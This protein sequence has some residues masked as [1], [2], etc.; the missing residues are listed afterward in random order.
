MRLN[1]IDYAELPL[2]VMFTKGDIEAIHE[3]FKDHSDAIKNCKR[4]HAMEQIAV[5]FADINAKLEEV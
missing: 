2:S 4:P 3:F 1:Y 5:C